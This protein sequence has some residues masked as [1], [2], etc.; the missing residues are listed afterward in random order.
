MTD[1]EKQIISR[2]LNGADE[3]LG[4]DIF[5]VLTTAELVKLKGATIDT[6]ERI[7]AYHGPPPTPEPE[8]SEPEDLF[9]WI[10]EEDV[11]RPKCKD[12][13]RYLGAGSHSGFHLVKESNSDSTYLDPNN[14]SG[15]YGQPL[16]YPDAQA[17]E[18]HEEVNNDD[19]S[20]C[21]SDD[22]SSY[23][24]TENFFRPP[25]SHPPAQS[26][27]LYLRSRGLDIGE[28]AHKIAILDQDF[29]YT[30]ESRIVNGYRVPEYWDMNENVL[31]MLT[32]VAR[33]P[34]EEWEVVGARDR[35]GKLYPEGY[36]VL[37]GRMRERGVRRLVSKT[38]EN[39]LW[40]RC[41]RGERVHTDIIR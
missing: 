3:G 25:R 15:Y 14:L 18:E 8:A 19:K 6:I 16:I 20:E 5:R 40:Y 9:D 35:F 30:H 7:K 37:K 24:S 28:I 2:W 13:I 11:P 41:K 21:D 33:A 1:E 36:R 32:E 22:S 10:E 4:P 38:L 26:L 31:E 12:L 29:L 34:L 39:H 27:I 17:V 23:D